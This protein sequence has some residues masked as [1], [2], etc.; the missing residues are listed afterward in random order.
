MKYEVRHATGAQRVYIKD[1]EKCDFVWMRN[2][3]S[4]Y[5]QGEC[6]KA[7]EAECARL[8]GEVEKEIAKQNELPAEI[9]TTAVK[10]LR[11]RIR[12]A[13]DKLEIFESR[14]SGIVDDIA[15]LRTEIH[16]SKNELKT[17]IAAL[18]GKQLENEL[19]GVTDYMRGKPVVEEKYQ[20]SEE[21]SIKPNDY[22]AFWKTPET[23]NPKMYELCRRLNA[24]EARRKAIT[25]YLNDY[26]Y[27]RDNLKRDLAAIDAYEEGK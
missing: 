11:Y 8:N 25:R 9:K 4:T 18:E 22:V 24:N 20:C 2:Y 3:E 5:S 6:L 26:C 21:G 15:G 1:K 7:A 14:W 27:S 16:K 17:R 10:K 23:I 13:E 12:M 19:S